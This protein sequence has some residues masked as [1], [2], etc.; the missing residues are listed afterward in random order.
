MTINKTQPC[1]HCGESLE[2][3]RGLDQFCEGTFSTSYWVGERENIGERII[4]MGET[5]DRLCEEIEA[6]KAN[7]STLKTH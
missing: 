6:L 5:I 4:R 1:S 3:H 2:H 7:L